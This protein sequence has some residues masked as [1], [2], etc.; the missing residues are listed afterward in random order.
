VENN[1]NTFSLFLEMQGFIFIAKTICDLELLDILNVVWE[2]ILI[3]LPL[4]FS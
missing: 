4:R 2:P 1:L 3:K